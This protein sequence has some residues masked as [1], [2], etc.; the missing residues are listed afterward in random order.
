MIDA[1]V[2]MTFLAVGAGLVLVGVLVLWRHS[3]AASCPRHSRLAGR[4][5]TILAWVCL[6]TG[7]SLGVYAVSRGADMNRLFSAV[8]AAFRNWLAA[9][10]Q[11][12]SK[13]Y[14][15]PALPQPEAEQVVDR[16]IDMGYLKFVSDSKRADVR[17]Q[18]IEAATKRYLDSDWD[19]ECVAGDMRSYPAD[20]EDLAEGQ[21]GATILLMQ[22]VL[23][24]EGVKLDRV[25]DD[26]GDER[27][28][29]VINGQ[30]HL[31]YDGDGGEDSWSLA[32]K[33][34][35]EI[36]DGLLETAGSSERLFA[37]YGG[38]DGR[39]I[40]LTEEMQDYIESI[41]DVMDPKWMPRRVDKAESR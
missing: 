28:E 15:P 9:F 11:Q 23:E 21:V 30:Q 22:P 20:R 24:R 33:R 37:V 40:L 16:L 7:T 12:P 10:N 27:Y 34:L 2:S 13:P 26:F 29:V 25:V 17:R 14:E 41:G 32:L 18:L 5:A 19:D 36:V 3:T 35:V 8:A 39:V 6:L 4:V 31:I 1:G 38:N